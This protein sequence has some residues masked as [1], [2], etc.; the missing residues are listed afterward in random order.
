MSGLLLQQ[1]VGDAAP[2]LT[3]AEI[4]SPRCKRLRRRAVFSCQHG[5]SLVSFGAA[6]ATY[7]DAVFAYP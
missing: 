5:R 2:I 1:S 7:A 6:E 3:G 4:F